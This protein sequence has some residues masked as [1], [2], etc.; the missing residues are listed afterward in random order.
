MTKKHQIKSLVF[1]ALV[2]VL[3]VLKVYLLG[4]FDEGEQAKYIQ[5]YFWLQFLI[6]LID[7]GYYWSVVRRSVVD[8][9]IVSELRGLSL[10]SIL[11]VF[12]FLPVNTLYSQLILLATITAWY[13]FRLQVFRIQGD[14]NTYYSMRMGKVLLDGLFVLG[15]FLMSALTVEMLLIVEFVSVFLVGVVLTVKEGVKNSFYFFGWG[16]LFSFD[17]LYSILKVLR[18]NIVRLLIP[19]FF[20]NQGVEGVLFMVLFYE[21]IAQY[22]SIEK[23]K[24]LLAG[25][26]RV[27]FYVVVYIFS[28]PA[29]YFGIYFLAGLMSWEFGWLEI[30]CVLLGGAARIFST[31]TLKAVKSKGFDLLV[32]LNVFIVVFG[33]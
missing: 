11:L 25:N 3:P 27:L 18:S 6:P 14:S 22:L 4:A 23:L 24:D 7:F 28:L 33:G 16:R 9:R 10:I 32:W 21:L 5:V 19:L 12:A 13:N 2:T 20:V 8:D 26:V 15:L 1:F 17:Y 31:Y 29:Q 30:C